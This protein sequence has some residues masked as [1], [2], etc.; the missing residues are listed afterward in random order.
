MPLT[1]RATPPALREWLQAF[2]TRAVV[3]SFLAV[4]A[5]CVVAGPFN[6]YENLSLIAR[7]PYWAGIVAFSIVTAISVRVFVSDHPALTNVPKALKVAGSTLLIALFIA[8]FLYVLNSLIWTDIPSLPDYW[9]YLAVT[10][11]VSLAV[12]IAVSLFSATPE[13]ASGNAEVPFLKRLPVHLGTDLVSLSVRDHYVEAVTTR[14]CQLLL[15]RFAD[16]ITELGNYD[17]LQIHRS[18]WVAA[19]AVAGTRRRSGKLM[20]VLRDG[21]ALPVSRSRV[22]I[23]RSRLNI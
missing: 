7:I 23:V 22:V 8:M 9:S 12:S 5:I 19:D 13:P 2:Q 1:G 15:M 16:A 6:T 20:I 18:H 10:V 4:T 17:G 14:G 11:P 21:R 3:V